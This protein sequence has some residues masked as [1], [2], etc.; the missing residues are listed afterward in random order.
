VTRRESSKDLIKGE[1][2]GAE[3]VERREFKYR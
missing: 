2:P 1:I 3:E